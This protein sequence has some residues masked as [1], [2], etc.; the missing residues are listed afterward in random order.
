MSTYE[1]LADLPLEIESYELAGLQ[2]DVSSDFGRRTTVVALHGAGETGIG[3]DV[4][5]TAEDH[6]RLQRAGPVF[7]LAG[8]HTPDSFS[9]LLGSLDL[10]PAAPPG[11]A[12]ARHY[13]RWG[14]ESA[15]LDLALR[16]R[17]QSLAEALGREPRPVSFVVSMRLG[18]P[19]RA[20]RVL[21]LLTDYPGTR[22][23]L[24]PTSDWDAALVEE[25]AAL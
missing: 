13:R 19:A 24:D 10:F 11:M 20:E 25:L 9:Q 5:Y 6:E 23:K 15:A 17:G 1:L 4:T 14:F 2:R 12:A 21:R 16:Q 7:E 22:F 18:D 3:E 8:A